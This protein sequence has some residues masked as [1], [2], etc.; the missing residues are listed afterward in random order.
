MYRFDLIGYAYYISQPLDIT[1]VGYTRYNTKPIHV[2]TIN[3][4]EVLYKIDY[5]SQY[6]K[7]DGRLVLVL[8]PISRYCNGFSLYYQGHYS[9]NYKDGLN[10]DGYSLIASHSKDNL[11]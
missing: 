4:N 2:S 8:G 9:T 7:R 10:T 1:W 6:Y 3:R 5:I 11:S